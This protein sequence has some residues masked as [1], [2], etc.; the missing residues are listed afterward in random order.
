MRNE[1]EE[2]LKKIKKKLRNHE[3]A[4]EWPFAIVEC[5][6]LLI[7]LKQLGLDDQH[8]KFIDKLR[9]LEEQEDE[10]KSEVKAQYENR[11]KEF[12]EIDLTTFKEEEIKVDDYLDLLREANTSEARRPFIAY[13]LLLR[14]LAIIKKSPDI[15][16]ESF[17]KR[18]NDKLA[19]EKRLHSVG[20]KVEDII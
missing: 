2:N 20:R 11:P 4:G 12:D 3:K 15:F 7:L 10:W 8:I 1:R 9:K 19:L 6:K 16:L 13:D 17:P 5:K 18:V 14:C